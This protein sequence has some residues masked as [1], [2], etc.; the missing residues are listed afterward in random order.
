M[1]KKIQR[2]AS[3]VHYNHEIYEYTLGNSKV[4][5]KSPDG[6]N[7]LYDKNHIKGDIRPNLLKRLFR[8]GQRNIKITSVDVEK[9]IARH[10]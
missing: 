1:K 9:F 7:A 6:T 3:L 10:Y 4:L 5:I 2:K 8:I